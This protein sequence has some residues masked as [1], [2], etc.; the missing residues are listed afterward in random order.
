MKTKFTKTKP[1]KANTLAL[2]LEQKKQSGK[3][4]FFLLSAALLFG[5]SACG[6]SEDAVLTPKPDAPEITGVADTDQSPE[7]SIPAVQPSDEEIALAAQLA[8]YFSNIS[9]STSLK[10]NFCNNPVMTQRLGADPYALVYNDRVYLYMTGDVVEYDAS[11]NSKNNTYSKVKT[12]CVISSADL[13]NWTDHGTIYA[14]GYSGAAV[15]AKNSW[16]PAVAVKEIDGKP[17]F[18]LYFSNGAG[19]IGVLSADSPTGPFTDPLGRALITS[20]T[21]NCSTVTW[22]FDPAVLIDDD[23]KAYLYFG[24]GVP[25]GAAAHPNT[26]RVVELGEDMISLAGTPVAI[27]APYLFEDSGINKIGDTYYYSYC[28]N[29]NIDAEATAEYGIKNA[30]IAYMTSD[31]P[32]GP[33]TLQ[34][35][36]LKNPG[37]FFGCYGN[38][39]HSIFQFKDQWYIAYHTQILERALG[40]SGGYRCT[41]LD[42]VDVLE[43]GTISSISATRHGVKAVDVLNPYELTEAETIQQMAG[44][45]TTQ[46][47]NESTYYGSGNMVLSEIDTG[48]W[49]SVVNVDFGEGASAF[50]ASVHAEQDGYGVVKVCIDDAEADA[51]AYLEIQPDGTAVCREETAALLSELT[52]VHTLY[53]VFYGSGYT[54]DYW[55]FN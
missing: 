45:N 7:V 14:A 27:D 2:N 44:L 19:S 11:G 25:E 35:A 54:M 10:L 18:F 1:I 40:I 41:Q 34:S 46:Y 33:F 30:Q 24:G 16:A 48:D 31:S 15:W 5:L 55:Y 42:T 49:L 37:E 26:A 23:G 50:T 22:I 17:K 38:N 47:G 53:L 13:V 3:K 28:T 8:E 12:I 29:W 39:H 51:V 20:S 32:M 6:T 9:L 21:E 52:G 4:P 36:I 43:D